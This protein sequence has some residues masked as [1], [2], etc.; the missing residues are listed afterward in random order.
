MT[1]GQRTRVR[2]ASTM[3]A[4]AVVVPA[5]APAAEVVSVTQQPDRVFHVETGASFVAADAFG[6]WG[7]SLRGGYLATQYLMTGVGLET[8]RLHAEGTVPVFGGAFSQT[9]QSTLAAGFVRAQLPTRFVT[10]YAE[11]ALGFTAIH[12]REGF[13]YQC[14]ESSF[15]GGGAAFG[16]DGHVIPSM[17]VGLRAG[18][19]TPGLGT[20]TAAGGPWGYDPVAL[21]TMAVTLA[22]RW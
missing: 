10:P 12:G 21:K 16:V 8:A 9:F 18:V 2:I 22:Y 19:R 14:K 7:L 13:N 15:A 1:R 6:G 5:A 20:C 4:L 3:A 17:T 11:L